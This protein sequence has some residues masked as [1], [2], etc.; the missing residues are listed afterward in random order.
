MKLSKLSVAILATLAASTTFAAPTQLNQVVVTAN[1]ATQELASVTS[2]I[3]IITREQIDAKNYQNLGDAVKAVPGL[4]VKGT[5]G[6]GQS[7]SIFMRG[8]SSSDRQ[9]LVLIDGVE[10]TEAAGIGPSIAN[11]QLDNVERIEILKGAQSGVWGANASAGVINIITIKGQ[12]I[13]NVT[14]E[15]GTNNA[16]KMATT[17]GAGNEKVDFAVNFA[18]IQTDGFTAVKPYKG[19]RKLYESDEFNQTDLSFKMGFSPAAG[20]RFET[21]IKTTSADTQ[22]DSSD[23]NPITFISTPNPNDA[24]SNSTYQNQMRQ[25]QYLYQQDA[26]NGRLYISDQKSESSF[27]SGYKTEGVIENYGGQLGY[28]YGAKN[29]V[30]GAVEQKLFKDILGSKK[31]NNTGY[32]LSNTHYILPSLVFNGALRY[33]Q[34]DAFE[35]AVTGKVGLK[36]AFTP[37]I[38]VSA[39]YGT[40]YNAPSLTQMSAAANPKKLKPEAVQSFDVTLG[41]YGAQITYFESNT[42]DLITGTGNWPNTYYV[43]SNGTSKTTGWEF[44]YDQNIKAIQ[45]DFNLNATLLEAK[46]PKGQFKAYIPEQ[47]ASISLD[48]YSLSKTHFGL[49]TRYVGTNYSADD[50]KGAQIGEYFVTDLNA[51]YQFNKSLSVYAKIVNIADV[52]YVSSVVDFPATNTTPQY[53]YD[54]GGIQWFVGIR[55]KL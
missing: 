26:W 28:Q 33:D 9:V 14:L 48:N 39:N 11:I 4:S 21:L 44:N 10:Q 53:V 45:T 43:N 24:L 27:S 12:K 23:Y 1:N 41:A 42:E 32:A 6:P 20:H 18:R 19:N 51:D 52:D 36:N 29:S 25:L 15:M 35:D 22:F 3:H 13:A 8:A 50:K 55:G 40:G 47:Q 49:E 16:R 46:N 30:Q 34:Y 5:G 54:N 7:T 37:D 31:Y 38:F 17:L 2:N